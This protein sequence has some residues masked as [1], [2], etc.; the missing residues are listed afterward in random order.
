M[1][2]YCGKMETILDLATT[3]T[4]ATTFLTTALP[5]GGSVIGYNKERWLSYLS[6]LDYRR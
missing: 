3:I 4:G 1:I 5:H 2:P 6:R